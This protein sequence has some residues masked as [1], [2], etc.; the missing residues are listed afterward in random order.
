M[1]KIVLINNDVIIR[2]IIINFLELTGYEVHASENGKKGIKQI[3]LVKPDLILCCVNM[4]NLDGYEVLR[5]LNRIPE[6]ASIPFI[7]LSHETSKSD[8]RKGM[9]FG[10]DDYIAIPFKEIDLLDAIEA[11]IER[12]EHL[13]NN[14]NVGIEG[15]NKFI[16]I[17]NDKNL[18]DSICNKRETRTYIK[19]DVIFKED[20][21]VNFIYFIVKGK[22]KRI[23]TDS[24]GK[25]FLDDI[26]QE[27]EFFGYLN[28]FKG[29]KEKHQRTAI[30]LEPTEIVLIPKKDFQNLIKQNR[31]IA[32]AFIKILSGNVLDKEERLLQL[33]YASVRERVANVLLKLNKKEIKNGA[34]NSLF[35]IS[36]DNLA[37]IVGTSKESLIRTLTEL[38]KEKII[39]T[40]RSAIKILDKKRLKKIA[41]GF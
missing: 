27:G 31:E 35:E 14:F 1:K 40:G 4:P 9:N 11:R 26:H 33:A 10:A 19:N 2:K 17:V 39:K 23:E 29:E 21:F 41:K 13:K 38:K 12:S 37:H 6:T 25:E 30:A 8:I 16:N 34:S 15:L 32:S 22:V 36:R 28:F 20:D 5:I 24:H 18:L 3:K 7:F